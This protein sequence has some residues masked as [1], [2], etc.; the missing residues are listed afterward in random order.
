MTIA[1]NGDASPCWPLMHNH[2]S[3]LH[4]KPRKVNK[5]IIGSVRE[6]SLEELWLDQAYLNYREKVQRFAFAPCTF[7][8]GCELS[9][10]NEEDCMGNEAP[11]CGGCLW[12]Q[13]VIQ[14]P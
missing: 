1:W 7:C 9:E 2:T 10:A 8:G 13:G 5:H 12:A 4:G 3:Y 14:C 6:R 11:A